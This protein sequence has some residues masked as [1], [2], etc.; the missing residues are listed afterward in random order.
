MV[1]AALSIIVYPQMRKTFQFRQADRGLTMIERAVLTAGIV[2]F[3]IGGL[4]KIGETAAQF[5]TQVNCAFN[6]QGGD[7][8]GSG[9]ENDA[10]NGGDTDTSGNGG[11]DSD[12]KS[13]S[14]NSN[15]KSGTTKS[16]PNT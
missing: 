15:R 8:C 5:G 7:E 14:S 3:I 6:A 12:A 16:T 4:A 9:V 10:Q 13:G 2:I 1:N 11:A